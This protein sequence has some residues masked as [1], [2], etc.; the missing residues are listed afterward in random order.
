MAA[1]RT[2]ILFA[3]VIAAF[4]GTAFAAM[5]VMDTG[6]DAAAL[7]AERVK[8]Q[9]AHERRQR[10]RKPD[11]GRRTGPAA[12][13]P[14]AAAAPPRKRRRSWAARAEAVCMDA[15]GDSLVLLERS[16]TRTPQEIL[17]LLDAAVRLS[18]Q[19]TERIARLG[20]A[21]DRRLHARLMSELWA[22]LAADRRDVASLKKRWS[23]AT[24]RRMIKRDR[25][26]RVI[27]RLFRRLGA[28]ACADL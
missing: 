18:G 2:L 20:P 25:E 9:Q 17:Q 11:S 22:S 13:A 7:R 21:P 27:V 1:V 26:D 6:P 4:G 19:V 5:R 23:D 16:P 12:A 3:A 15:Y 14:A 24:V 10:K 28:P 8:Q